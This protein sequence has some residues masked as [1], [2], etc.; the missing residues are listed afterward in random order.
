MNRLTLNI[1]LLLLFFGMLG[2]CFQ[3]SIMQFSKSKKDLITVVAED[4]VED[5]E[6]TSEKETEK[7][8]EQ[9]KKEIQNNYFVIEFNYSFL[10]TQSTKTALCMHE[11][12][13]TKHPAL[14]INKPPPKV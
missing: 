13:K 12:K 5:T 10:K 11:L 1:Y 2:S 7:N 14:T 4:D 6:D 9:E 8:S 3:Y